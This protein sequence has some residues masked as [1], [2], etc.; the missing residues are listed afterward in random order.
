VNGRK[1]KQIRNHA[2]SILLDWLKT[3]VSEEEAAK[4]DENNFEDYLPSQ[5]HIY[6]NRKIM[7]SAYSFKWFI[8]KIKKI[9]KKERSRD[10]RTIKLDELLNVR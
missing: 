5:G 3:M 2:K 9:L 4:L 8:K 1:A 10:V 6:A 7:L